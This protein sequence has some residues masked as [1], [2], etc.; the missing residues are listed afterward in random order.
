MTGGPTTSQQVSYHH[1]LRNEHL[2]DCILHMQFLAAG[3]IAVSQSSHAPNNSVSVNPSGG[4]RF[5][6]VCRQRGGSG[7]GAGRDRGIDPPQL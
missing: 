3:F 7:V 2:P 6:D 5:R 1:K 4:N